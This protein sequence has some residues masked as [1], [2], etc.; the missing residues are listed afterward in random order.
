MLAALPE[1]PRLPLEELLVDRESLAPSSKALL[2][3]IIGRNRGRATKDSER[4]PKAETDKKTRIPGPGLT[5]TGRALSYISVVTDLS[6]F[7]MSV[8][9]RACVTARR[10]QM[11]FDS[12]HPLALITIVVWANGSTALKLLRCWLRSYAS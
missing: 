11:S 2:D 1:M 6:K 9:I 5:S 12:H 4:G 3:D 8:R 10:R 7:V